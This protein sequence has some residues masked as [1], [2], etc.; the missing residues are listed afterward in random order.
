MVI[1][2]LS[3][4]GFLRKYVVVEHEEGALVRGK[5]FGEEVIL[6]GGSEL[7]FI[8]RL[9][10]GGV[11]P[12]L[13]VSLGPTAV[14]VLRTGDV[15]V[16]SG[17]EAWSVKL[18]DDLLNSADEQTRILVGKVREGSGVNGA[19][20]I[21]SDPVACTVEQYGRQEGVPVL[22]VRVV[23]N[24]RG[25]QENEAMVMRLVRMIIDGGRKIGRATT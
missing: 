6:G 15:I 13:V 21:I 9:F 16:S 18:L 8:G 25:E 11:R 10:P 5:L 1:A 17:A 19:E 23:I 4:F 14:P 20:L 2:I 3:S 12:D 24:D 22:V 7:E